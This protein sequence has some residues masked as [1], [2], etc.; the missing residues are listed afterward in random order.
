VKVELLIVNPGRKRRIRRRRR[1]NP[2]RVRRVGPSSNSRR[3]KKKKVGAKKGKSMAAKKRRSTVRRRKSPARRRKVAKRKNPK[4][5][6]AGKKAARTRKRMAAK[7]R[8]RPAKRRNPARSP[9]SFSASMPRSALTSAAKAAGIKASGTNAQIAGRLNA[10]KK[11]RTGGKKKAT[12]KTTRRKTTRRTAAKRTTAKRAAPKRRR[13]MTRKGAARKARAARRVRGKHTTSAR[14]VIKRNKGKKT[15]AARQRRSVAR[16]YMKARGVAQR[17]KRGKLAPGAAK[18][19]KAYGLTRVNPNG[20]NL[21]AAAKDFRAMLV[22]TILPATGGFVGAAAL[23]QMI[24]TKIAS[25]KMVSGQ[26]AKMPALKGAVVPVT[27]LGLTL[28]AFAALRASKKQQKM[29]MPVLIGGGIATLVHTLLHTK[30]GQ[31]LASRLKLPLALTAGT[32]AQAEQAAEDA[33]AVA[34]GQK[35]QTGAGLAGYMSVSQYLGAYGTPISQKGPSWYGRGDISPVGDFVDAGPQEAFGGYMAS[36]FPVHTPG[37]GDN[38]SVHA[39]L[40]GAYP[41]GGYDGLG[42]L[43]Q[44]PGYSL[45]ETPG[46]TVVEPMGEAGIFG[47]KSAIG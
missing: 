34:S 42:A 39:T 23:G 7:R 4:R 11:R 10:A 41:P 14:A 26:I 27:T 24:G 36:D 30:W 25:T 47:G 9:T 18:L 2:A 21:K 13:K 5:V 37:P 19:A 31:G 12:K 6:A 38:V 3:T 46:G 16:T 1:K 40:E 17:A 45:E 22:P 28:G 32:D 44:L 8:R 29:A 43:P 35:D 33:A 15:R 20:M